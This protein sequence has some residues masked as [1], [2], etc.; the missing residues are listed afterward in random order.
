MCSAYAAWH[1]FT[2]CAIQK[3]LEY[4]SGGMYVASLAFTAPTA[5]AALALAVALLCVASGNLYGAPSVGS[6]VAHVPDLFSAVTIPP[7]FLALCA[8]A[9]ADAA[10]ASS[11]DP[12]AERRG[13]E[14]GH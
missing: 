8:L 11:R 14:G 1:M 3:A 5:L 13:H 9:A 2:P 6:D 4:T 7:S 12:L 10:T